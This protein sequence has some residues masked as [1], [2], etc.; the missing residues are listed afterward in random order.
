MVVMQAYTQ[1]MAQC[2]LDISNNSQS[3]LLVDLQRYS[4]ELAAA[5]VCFWMSN[6]HR[7]VVAFIESL[8]I[9][10]CGQGASPDSQCEDLLVHTYFPGL[11]HVL[12]SGFTCCASS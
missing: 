7:A 1:K 2:L 8:S 6:A 11:Y 10:S 5:F 9:N 3:T 12:R 4:L